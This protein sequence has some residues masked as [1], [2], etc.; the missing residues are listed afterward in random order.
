MNANRR[1]IL[2]LLKFTDL[3]VVGVAFV[4]GLI[5][6]PVLTVFADGAFRPTRR[7]VDI[8]AGCSC[9]RPGIR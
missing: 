1:A 6:I 5:M 2:T 7:R 9:P 8:A 3:G 4:A